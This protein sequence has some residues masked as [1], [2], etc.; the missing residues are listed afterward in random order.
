MLASDGCKCQPAAVKLVAIAMCIFCSALAPAALAQAPESSASGGSS[1]A[2]IDALS[3]K[4]DEQ[5]AKIDVLSQQ[6]QKLEQSLTGPKMIGIPEAAA[7]SSSPA[8][9]GAMTAE[10]PHVQS[11]TSHTVARGE[12]LTSIAKM[13]KVTID[14]LQKTNHI[15]DDRKLQIGQ[16]LTIPMPTSG[17]AT[18]SPGASPSVTPAASP[19]ASTP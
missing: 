13:H 19:S 11:G 12:T 4:I 9:I 18:S 10:T 15:T 5:N 14:E 8:A 7:Q 16:T 3:K 17:S 6:I 1:A 2:Q